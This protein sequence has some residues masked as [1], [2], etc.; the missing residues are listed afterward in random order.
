M[1]KSIRA[2]CLAAIIATALSVTATAQAA[3]VPGTGGGYYGSVWF[4]SNQG[5]VVAGAATWAECNARLQEY[6][7]H[8]ITVWG[9]TV[10]KYTPCHYRPPFGEMMQEEHVGMDVNARTP[11]ESGGVV[12][13]ITDEIIR[14]RNQYR[15][16]E[17]EASMG[18]IYGVTDAK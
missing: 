11:I 16:D 13:V 1:K 14:A 3:P 10:V 9:W 12:G 17:Y 2:H 5:G 6:I 4:D 18:A 15:A 7:Q 8:A